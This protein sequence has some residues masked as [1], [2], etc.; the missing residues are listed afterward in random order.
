MGKNRKVP[1]KVTPRGKAKSKNK[2]KAPVIR[3]CAKCLE[4]HEIPT[5]KRCNRL[6][7]PG[8]QVGTDPLPGP[9]GLFRASSSAESV[10]AE[11][12]RLAASRFP[13]GSTKSGSAS[14]PQRPVHYSQEQPASG[15]EEEEYDEG[16]SDVFE[17]NQDSDSGAAADGSE[18]E[19]DADEYE[20]TE[21][22]DGL[23]G[24]EADDTDDSAAEGETDV[25][26][27]QPPVSALQEFNKVTAQILDRLEKSEQRTFDLERQLRESRRQPV[28]LP[29][30]PTSTDR[31]RS[32]PPVQRTTDRSR[33]Q[34][35]SHFS[36]P[37]PIRGPTTPPR[38]SPVP[39]ATITQASS[40]DRGSQARVWDRWGWDAATEQQPQGED[41]HTRPPSPLPCH[42]GRKG[43]ILQNEGTGVPKSPR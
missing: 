35:P 18:E 32:P 41:T 29:A 38:P 37:P 30:E 27:N 2:K 19:D 36:L 23:D 42:P 14:T 6:Q 17:S 12:V 39:S 34:P 22:E 4:R 8:L 25:N 15:E 1:A 31:M 13:P 24:P 5:G 21:E 16:D 9:P 3:R 43:P 20:E 10:S 11:E 7:T 33:L 40:E 28:R 26:N